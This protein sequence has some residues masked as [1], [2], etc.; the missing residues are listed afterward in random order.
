M[1]KE[2]Q[3]EGD[4]KKASERKVVKEISMEIWK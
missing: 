2:R 4:R 3:S 1:E